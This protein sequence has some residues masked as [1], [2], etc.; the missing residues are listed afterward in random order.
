ME[1]GR[2]L[3]E[4]TQIGW[5]MLGSLV[6]LVIFLA[7]FPR[8]TGAGI[9]R[10]ITGW[11]PYME[12]GVGGVVLLFSTLTVRVYRD[13]LRWHFGP[14][15]FRFQIEIKGIE[16]ASPDTVPM[17]AGFGIHLTKRG[18]LHNVSG[19]KV[20]VVKRKD[21][22]STLLGS[23]EP[24]RLVAALNRAIEAAAHR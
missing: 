21:G 9:P 4:H 20:V 1:T 18:W 6:F 3:Y 16:A 14:G 24:E 8:L 19:R 10:G 23:D 17:S 12:I 13:R 2:P 7:T 22:R 11:L 5:A 15:V